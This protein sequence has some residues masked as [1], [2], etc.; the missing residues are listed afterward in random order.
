MAG[1]DRLSIIIPALDD[2]EGS[3]IDELDDHIAR[4]GEAA[5]RCGVDRF[6]LGVR[7]TEG[8]RGPWL[9]QS[10]RYLKHRARVAGN[11]VM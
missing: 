3:S 2:K 5:P 6:D 4:N 1:G 9:P 10:G 11:H 7:G 8:P